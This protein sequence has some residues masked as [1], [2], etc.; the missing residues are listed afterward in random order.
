MGEWIQLVRDVGF[1]AVVAWFVLA[2]LER[3]LHALT[4]EVRQ[5]RGAILNGGTRRSDHAP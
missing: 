1:P 4:D 3:A 5:L 2:R